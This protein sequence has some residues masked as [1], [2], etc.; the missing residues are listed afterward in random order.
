MPLKIDAKPINN[1]QKEEQTQSK[2]QKCDVKDGT[3]HKHQQSVCNQ[4]SRITN[5]D[6]YYAHVA[7][8]ER[9][10]LAQE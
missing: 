1:I 2:K 8:K 5:C 10:I 3:L 9:E 7:L 4:L 6:I